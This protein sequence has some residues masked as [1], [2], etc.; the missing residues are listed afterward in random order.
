[1]KKA[2][3]EAHWSAYNAQQRCRAVRQL[4]REVLELAGPAA[5]RNAVD[6]GCGAGRE[7]R[8]LLEAGW[9]VHAI[10]AEPSVTAALA[11]VDDDRLTIEVTRFAELQALPDADLVH[12]GYSLP[13]QSPEQFGRLWTLIRSCLR[14]GGWFA[15]NLFGE[16]DS[17]AGAEGMTFLSGSSAREL[18]DGL[19]VLYWTE[20]DEDGQAYSGPKHWHVFDVIARRA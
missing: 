13:Y 8:A 2:P 17:W 7:T 15:G 10:D 11:D 18:F 19:D 3:D 20:L 16:R 9:R 4:C 6:L 14:P 5:G 12:A 1:M